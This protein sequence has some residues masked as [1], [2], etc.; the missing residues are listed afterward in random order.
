MNLKHYHGTQITHAAAAA[1]A[2]GA[3]V[4][5]RDRVGV[6]IGINV[7]A[8]TG[9]VPTLTVILEGMDEA[10]GVYYPILTSAAIAATGLTVLTVLP[11]ITA[12]AN[13]SAAAPM[14][15]TWRVR[16]TI[17]GTTPAVTATVSATGL[18]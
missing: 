16:T 12:A 14:P 9:T 5:D 3:P 10:T 4:I 7:T 11:G 6:L 15:I 8:I 18:N 17:A 13:V 2:T 1:G